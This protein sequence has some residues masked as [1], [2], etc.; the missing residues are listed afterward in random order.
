M[1]FTTTLLITALLSTS[2]QALAARAKGKM[3][4]PDFTQGEKIPEDAKHDWNL[5]AIGARG[6]MYS[7]KMSTAGARQIVITQVEK[8]SPADGILA[9]GDVILG[10]GGNKFS[11][12]PRTELGKAL[13]TAESTTG[14]GKLTLT[15]W[16][17][18]KTED[19]AVKL[20]VLG[21][22]SATAP[23]DCAK[24]KRI[25]ERGCAA[26][27]KRMSQRSYKQNPITRSLNA[28]A[29]LASGDPAYVPL[30]K[31]EAVW[32]AGFSATSMQSWF[33]GYAMMLLSEYVMATGD[34]SVMPGLRRLALETANGQSAVGSWGHKFAQPD[35]RLYGYGMMNSP[36]LPLTISLVMARAAGVHDPAVDRAIER[37]A[38]LMR[39]YIG[40]GAIPYGDHQPWTQTHD[41]NGKCGMAAVLFN[42]L[43]EKK[44]AEFFSRMSVASHG[45]ERDGG[46]TGNFF[47]IL[48]ALPGVA[49]SGPNATGAWMKE[50]GS[51]YFDLA[52]QWDGSLIHQGPPQMKNDSYAG[53]DCSGAYLLAYAL[54]LKKIWLTGK[55]PAA[56]AALDSTAAQSLIHQGRGWSHHD[57][58]SGYDGLSDEQ[59]FK[60]LGS[61]SPIVRERVAMALSRRKEAPVSQLI[62]LLDAPQIEARY[63]ACKA[64]E[65]LKGRAA[66]AVKALQKTLQHDDL[67]LRVQA[68][69]AL[70]AI[71]EKAMSTV[72]ELLERIAKGP[73][74][75]DPRGME[76][77][78]LCFAV[79]GSMLKK[80]LDGVDRD[81][82]RKA[83]EAGLHNQDGKARG[84]IGGIYHKLSYEEIKPL[85]PAIQ[86]AVVKP[87][88]SGE[89]FASNIRL[90]GIEL[91]AKHR[92]KEGMDLC[93]LVMDIHNWGAGARIPRCLN[94][95]ASYGTAAK[96]MLPRLRQLEADLIAHPKSK[97]FQSEIQQTRSVISRIEEATEPVELRGIEG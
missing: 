27:A 38:G 74:E 1:K 51:W 22:Y 52:R 80:S 39:F 9:I 41:D 3:K 12:D 28:L 91:M 30:V 92:I 97:N 2:G 59:L 70:A 14:G 55:R 45:S 50:F 23:Y 56:I 48:W 62:N 68:A 77:R 42:L 54:P 29:L 17:D 78:Y 44:G 37:S 71:G 40:K 36:G 13:S 21:D 4:M 46:H 15:R 43:G 19:V 86:E 33:Y 57:R 88:P 31:K 87:A 94:A 60:C 58:N 73:T 11:S 69:Y 32:A 26:L 8:S 65:L 16:R 76:Q 64:L 95:L 81:Q 25:L 93:F 61:W 83:V 89:M 18:G 35:G 82:V 96:P 53:W 66:P 75:A 5:G 84:E 24:S 63:G 20:E 90:T 10:V 6:W 67:W 85:I 72:P 79:F 34:E 49:Q 47:N 7:D